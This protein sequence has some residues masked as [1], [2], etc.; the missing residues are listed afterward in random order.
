[1]ATLDS[2]HRCDACQAQAYTVV[3]LR[4][5]G[6]LMLCAHHRREHWPK[7][8]PLVV[9]LVDETDRL[10]ESIKDDGHAVG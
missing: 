4:T 7:L 6:L 8:E 10:H 3:T 2:R 9:G 5:G 1:M